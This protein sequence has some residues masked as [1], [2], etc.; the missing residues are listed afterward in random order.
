MSA[1]KISPLKVFRFF[2]IVAVIL[3]FAYWLKGYSFN[4]A[5]ISALVWAAIS[6]LVFVLTRLYWSARGQSC[7][8]CEKILH[9]DDK[10]AD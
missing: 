1:G 4:L 3:G 6:T 9:E 8:T 5:V 10:A 7:S 2:S